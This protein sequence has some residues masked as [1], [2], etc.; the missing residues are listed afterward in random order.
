MFYCILL[1]FKKRSDRKP[2]EVCKLEREKT[3][4]LR[5]PREARLK[6]FTW[7]VDWEESYFSRRP[8][9]QT[10]LCI[11]CVL[12]D[13]TSLW[14]RVIL[15]LCEAWLAELVTICSVTASEHT[16]MLGPYS[17]CSTFWEVGV[18]FSEWLTNRS[19]FVVW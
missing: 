17:S 19:V 1:F 9:T 6:K 8:N 12:M 4:F 18:S 11:K 15:L 16:I 13:L 2:C 3:F 5:L 14:N 10:L 7:L